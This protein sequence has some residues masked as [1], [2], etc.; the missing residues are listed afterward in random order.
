[1]HFQKKTD[2]LIQNSPGDKVYLA[3]INKAFGNG[4]AFRKEEY[5]EQ[6]NIENLK[7]RARRFTEEAKSLSS[8]FQYALKSRDKHKEEKKT[9]ET[10]CIVL[11]VISGI[12]LFCGLAYCVYRFLAP[13]HLDEY[14]EY[15]DY[16]ED[17]EDFSE[18]E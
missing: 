1:M 15:D 8:D 12:I 17:S 13:N 4:K 14:D 6:W 9:T 2:I 7:E 18:E 16:D 5:M 3:V 10:I 11:A